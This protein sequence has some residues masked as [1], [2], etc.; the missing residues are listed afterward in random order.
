MNIYILT[1]TSIRSPLRIERIV[2]KSAQIR[3]VKERLIV[4][5]YHFQLLMLFTFF[6]QLLPILILEYMRF[7][8]KITLHLERHFLCST[9]E[10]QKKNSSILMKIWFDYSFSFETLAKSKKSTNQTVEYVMDEQVF[11]E[12]ESNLQWTNSY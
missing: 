4:F 12:A 7:F 2:F 9:V 5:I 11:F 8:W 3:L 6:K 1:P 10:V